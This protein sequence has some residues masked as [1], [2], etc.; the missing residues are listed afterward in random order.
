MPAFRQRLQQR[1]R[2]L[3]AEG[4]SY[5]YSGTPHRDLPPPGRPGQLF[6]GVSLS[7]G[8]LHPL[9]G[10][11]LRERE[12]EREREAESRP[13][14]FSCPYTCPPPSPCA[15]AP[16][17]ASHGSEGG[18]LFVVLIWFGCFFMGW[19]PP[20]P[21]AAAGRSGSGRRRRGPVRP[22]AGPPGSPESSEA[23]Y[24]I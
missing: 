4:A 2:I 15:R 18:V 5:I 3:K 14:S 12:R 22:P 8:L 10:M 13:P 19:R 6:C 9:R 21:A 16:P 17:P 23:H 11:L 20:F 1:L 7:C 24:G